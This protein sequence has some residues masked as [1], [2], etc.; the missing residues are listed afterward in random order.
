MFPL[1]QIPR[2]VTGCIASNFLLMQ[3]KTKHV[4]F[5]FTQ[6][7]QGLT[8]YICKLDKL[9]Q[10]ERRG[11][12]LIHGIPKSDQKKDDSLDTLLNIA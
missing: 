2:D 7:K 12:I 1:W 11:N 5:C 8:T 9:E 4:W 6:L 3:C 10:Y